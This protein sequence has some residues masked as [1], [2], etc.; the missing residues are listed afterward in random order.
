MR[1]DCGYEA[2]FTQNLFDFVFFMGVL[3]EH[4]TICNGHDRTELRPAL[5]KGN[6]AQ[7]IVVS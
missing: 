5:R 6:R 3:C 2:H 1:V 7:S 4:Q